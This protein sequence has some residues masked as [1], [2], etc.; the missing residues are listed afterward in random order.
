MD[1]RGIPAGV[2]PGDGGL[3]NAISAR[4]IEAS[5]ARRGRRAGCLR[6]DEG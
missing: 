6:D 1:R 2:V 4:L 5:I 3:Q